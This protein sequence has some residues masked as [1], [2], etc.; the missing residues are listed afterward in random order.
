MKYPTDGRICAHRINRA[1]GISPLNAVISFSVALQ[2]VWRLLLIFL[3][4]VMGLE[5]GRS[6]EEKPTDAISVDTGAAPSLNYQ[7]RVLSSGT[8]EIGRPV[9]IGIYGS[10]AS[11]LKSGLESDAAMVRK[12]LKL[13]LNGVPMEGLV[14]QILPPDEHEVVSLKTTDPRR[15]QNRTLL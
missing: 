13:Y 6:H 4:V 14:P 8:I 15:I 9:L 1:K 11:E 2:A 10:F 7:V 12:N 3:A 5:I